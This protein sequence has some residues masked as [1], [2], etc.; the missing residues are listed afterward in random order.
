MSYP[1]YRD[2]YKLNVQHIYDLVLNFKPTINFYETNPKK[3][4]LY[5]NKYYFVITDLWQTNTELNSL[6]DYFSEKIRINCKVINNQ[7][8]IDYWNKNKHKLL[9]LKLNII[10]LKEKIYHNVKLCNNFR[11]S[12]IITILKYF[13]V[14]RYL[15]ISAGWGDRLIASILCKLKFYCAC[16]PNLDLH[17][18]YKE[19]IDTLVQ[20]PNKR[21]N[22]N[23][24]AD[25]FEVANIPDKK[26]DMVFSSPPFFDLEI[27]SAHKGDSVV[28]YNKSR[29]WL[30][31]F[32][33]F[34]VLKAYNLLIKNGKMI[35]HIGKDIYIILEKMKQV[36][37]KHMQYYGII[38]YHEKDYRAMFAWK[39]LNDHKFSSE[40]INNI[41]DNIL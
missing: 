36:F 24:I 22:Y 10:D 2:Y 39:K 3:L 29:D 11:V 4:E 18:C 32:F 31:N 19:M 6:T 34:S 33:M 20:D 37:D 35:L 25:G 28:K 21:K 12:I 30:K 13:N 38:Y 1:L 8:P 7:K 23:V 41:I 16:D 9:Q 17:P 14:K 15:D 26:Y 5:K 27:Y 40:E